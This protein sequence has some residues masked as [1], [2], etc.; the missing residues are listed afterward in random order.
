MRLTD[1]RF[2]YINSAST[3]VAD[4]FKRF[5]FRKTTDEERAARQLRTPEVAPQR[6]PTLRLTVR[7]DK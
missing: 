3:N 6:R 1:P 2:R 7:N 5:G 4:T